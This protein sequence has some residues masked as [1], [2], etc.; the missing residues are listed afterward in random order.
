MKGGGRRE[1]ERLELAAIFEFDTCAAGYL[2]TF[3]S[4]W[5]L[6]ADCNIYLRSDVGPIYL[7][8]CEVIT[9]WVFC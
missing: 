6:S 8:Y 5:I 4:P 1:A 2:A 9:R 3:T 7:F